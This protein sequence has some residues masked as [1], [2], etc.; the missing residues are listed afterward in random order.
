MVG[1]RTQS[2][3]EHTE[4]N[5]MTDRLVAEGAN[6]W[7]LYTHAQHGPKTF[8]H[9]SHLLHL[10]DRQWFPKTGPSS[11][12]VGGVQGQQCAQDIHRTQHARY[13]KSFPPQRKVHATQWHIILN[14]HMT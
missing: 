6:D 10:R 13:S 7:S 14:L 11:W 1:T 8:I 2:P 12:L 5:N 3:R 4:H 9:A